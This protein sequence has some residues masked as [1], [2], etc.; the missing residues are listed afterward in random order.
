MVGIGYRP[1]YLFLIV[2]VMSLL[3][4]LAQIDSWAILSDVAIR[5]VI[6]TRVSSERRLVWNGGG[7]GKCKW[8]YGF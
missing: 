8:S 6:S 1:A 7:V 4:W 3:F 2:G 5:I